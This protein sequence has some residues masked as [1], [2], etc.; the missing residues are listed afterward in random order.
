[1]GSA[2]AYLTGRFSVVRNR[3]IAGKAF[4]ELAITSF[5]NP[6]KQLDPM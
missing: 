3:T 2:L 4:L 6:T 5:L 1:M